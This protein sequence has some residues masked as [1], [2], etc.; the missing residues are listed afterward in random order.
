MPLFATAMT[1]SDF[2]TY[3]MEEVEANAA[4]LDSICKP[5]PNAKPKYDILSDA[6]IWSDEHPGLSS[7]LLGALRQVW[8]FRT[9]CILRRN[10]IDNDVIAKCIRLFPNWIGFLPERWNPTPEILAEYRRG[11]ITTRWCLRNLDREFQ[12][13]ANNN[14]MDAKGSVDRP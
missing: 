11:D 4:L 10:R 8:H 14:G 12:D 9:Y 3:G 13:E 7:N 5:D 1:D 2:A 6:I